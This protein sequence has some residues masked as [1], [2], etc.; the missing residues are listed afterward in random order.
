MT[1]RC[2]SNG[3]ERRQTEPNVN[4]YISAGTIKENAPQKEHQTKIQTFTV[5]YIIYNVDICT[6][7]LYQIYVKNEIYRPHLTNTINLRQFRM[8]NNRKN[9]AVLTII[10]PGR[11]EIYIYIYVN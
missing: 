1:P 6:I 8:E 5:Y 9:G 10:L 11:F 2:S 4:V 3:A 7:Y